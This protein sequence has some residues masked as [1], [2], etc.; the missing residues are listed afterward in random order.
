MTYF[1]LRLG[2]G[3]IGRV[4]S[5]NIPCMVC[6]SAGGSACGISHR[7][8]EGPTILRSTGRLDDPMGLSL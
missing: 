6:H 2:N 8:A 3:L 4:V 5:Q 7:E 1:L